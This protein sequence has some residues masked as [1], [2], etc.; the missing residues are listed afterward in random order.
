M[1]LKILNVTVS[2]LTQIIMQII[3]NASST[4]QDALKDLIQHGHVNADINT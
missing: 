4:V 3:K 1:V 2:I